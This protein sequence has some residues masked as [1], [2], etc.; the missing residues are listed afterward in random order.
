M[1]SSLGVLLF[2]FS[3]L[4][5]S[6]ASEVILLTTSTVDNSGLLQHLLAPLRSQALGSPV[7]A[8]VSSSGQVFASVRKGNGDLMLTHDPAGEQSLIEDGLVQSGYFFMH[9]DY[10]LVGPRDQHAEISATGDLLF[11]LR[12]I[13]WLQHKFLSRSDLSGTSQKEL[14]LWSQLGVNPNSNPNYFSN[15]QGMGATLLMAYETDS[16]TLSDSATWFNFP[17]ERRPDLII[18]Q[19]D[20]PD[21]RNQYS[22]YVTAQ[23]KPESLKIQEWLCTAGQQ[24]LLEFRNDNGDLQF[25]PDGC[26]RKWPQ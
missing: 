16:Y 15:G 17:D 6:A 7:K 3:S 2:L 4:A 1:R 22:L 24:L 14:R 26:K 12:Q 13:H 19:R 9:N 5:H 11:G 25:N 10:L 20:N 18:R 8:V 23:A 21:L